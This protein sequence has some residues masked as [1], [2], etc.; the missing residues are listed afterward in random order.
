M[1]RPDGDNI[2]ADPQFVD[3]ANGDYHSQVGSPAIDGGTAVGAPTTD[4]DDTL[5]DGVPDMGAYEWTGDRIYLPQV[6]K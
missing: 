6:I 4:L 5:R 1:L 3:A 2:A